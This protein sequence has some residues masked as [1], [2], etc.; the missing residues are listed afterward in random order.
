[1]RES[2]AIP[3]A[4]YKDFSLRV[5][6]SCRGLGRVIKAQVELTYRCNLHCAHCYTDPYNAREFLPREMTLAETTR[7]LDEM[8]DL[9]IL[10]LNLTGGEIFMHPNFFRIYDH[11]RRRGFLVMLYTNGTLF[12]PTIVD[13]LQQ[14]P[15]FSIDVSCHSVH[16]A[17]F[18]R[19]TR[20]PGSFRQFMRSM[21]LLR[22]SDL[23]IGFRTKAMSW[24]S[25]ELPDI[26]RFVES[27]GQAFRFTTALSPRLNGDLS[28]LRY[29]LPPDDVAAL[30]E[31]LG[32]DVEEPCNGGDDGR[33]SSDHL[34]RCGCA[35]TDIHV[36]AWGELGTCTM[37]YEHRASVRE[38]T[39]R[40]A[41]AKVFGEVRARRYASASPCRACAIHAFCDKTPGD[42]R[43]ECGDPE[44]PIPYDCD[45]ALN[46]AQ[47]ALRRTLLHPL[48]IR[49]EAANPAVEIRQG[50]PCY[51]AWAARPSGDR[52]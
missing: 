3:T 50:A 26:R 22:S 48:A 1:M 18:D 27:F 25:Q 44:A 21:E 31:H 29:R 5:H 6:S 40:D 24:N 46:R 39:V 34:Y 33:P 30:E 7:L 15:P 36:S 16:E 52:P 28:S 2:R 47:R 4:E 51:A 37:Q 10:Y 43:A 45:L 38:H 13:R 14:S 42:A 12:T 23:P 11:A 9:G 49:R 17:A 32:A 8:A 41:I 35:T 20:V 19:F